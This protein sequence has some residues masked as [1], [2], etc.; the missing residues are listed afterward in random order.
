ML[1]SRPSYL[2]VLFYL[3]C[4]SDSLVLTQNIPGMI[5]SE[6]DGCKSQNMFLECTVAVTHPHWKSAVISK[7]FFHA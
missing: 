5:V 3:I 4:C 6:I 1:L 7:E 2:E